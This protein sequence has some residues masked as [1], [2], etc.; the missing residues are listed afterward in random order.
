MSAENSTRYEYD[1]FRDGEYVAGGSAPSPAEA[2]SDADH[3]AAMYA[4]D[5]QV[6]VSFRA[7]L[8]VTRAEL[9]A[10]AADP[11]AATQS[12]APAVVN[13]EIKLPPIPPG[14]RYERTG[15]VTEINT[16]TVAQLR[17]YA[18]AAP[19]SAPTALQEN[20]GCYPS[21]T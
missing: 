10:L 19:S 12:T 8:E 17:E 20:K 7:C 21:S 3:Y 6:E 16:R 2:L 15:D 11:S 5:G 18:T 4:A 9:E 14:E 1:L 13:N